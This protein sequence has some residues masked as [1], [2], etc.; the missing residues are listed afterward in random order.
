MNGLE[1]VCSLLGCAEVCNDKGQF[2]NYLD[3]INNVTTN[4]RF[5]I[6]NSFRLS[7]N[8]VFI[9][10]HSIPAEI[11]LK[12]QC[13]MLV[14][15]FS[16]LLL[17]RNARYSQTVELDEFLQIMLLLQTVSCKMISVLPTLS[18]V[19]NSNLDTNHYSSYLNF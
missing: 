6:N 16:H 9:I 12:E 15:F 3:Q 2:Y 10:R 17:V 13:S 11:L 18:V 1:F 8:V 5:L 19:N 7:I 14:N 4:L